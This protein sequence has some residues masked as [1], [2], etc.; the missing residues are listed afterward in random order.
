MH[1]SPELR[2][3]TLITV[4]AQQTSPGIRFKG[5]SKHKALPEYFLFF[6][7]LF[8]FCLMPPE[9]SVQQENIFK[10]CSFYCFAVVL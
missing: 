2:V 6:K 10:F 4:W 1:R 3:I 5:K 7:L 9:V 8:Y